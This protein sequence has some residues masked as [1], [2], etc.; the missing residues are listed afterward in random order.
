MIEFF[1]QHWRELV[2]PAG[3]AILVTLITIPIFLAIGAW[4]AT[5]QLYGG[6]LAKRVVNSY[7]AV[8]RGTPLLIQV[9][10]IFYGLPL[11][12][13]RLHP[14]V[15]GILALSLNFGAYASEIVRSGLNSVAHGQHEAATML[16]M[17]RRQ[18]LRRVIFPQALV[19]SAPALAN[20][21][22]ELFKNT[23]LL[24]LITVAELIRGGRQLGVVTFDP[25]ASWILVAAFYVVIAG[26]AAFGMRRFER[27]LNRALVSTGATP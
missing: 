17:T 27:R 3:V 19:V 26:L 24:G 13:I 22:I 8:F 11:I 12:G 16:G 1:A 23:S 5:S 2:P 4:S 18:S 25:M 21:V 7:L 6:R 9:F 14:I 15:A 20:Q 10:W